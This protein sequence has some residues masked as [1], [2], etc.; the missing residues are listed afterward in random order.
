MREL[1][2][3]E[4]DF[5][6]LSLASRRDVEVVSTGDELSVRP[7]SKRFFRRGAVPFYRN[8]LTWITFLAI[9]PFVV[10]GIFIAFL[11]QAD[12]FL[13]AGTLTLIHENGI[14][15]GML[16]L[17]GNVDLGWLPLV[18]DIYAQRGLIIALI[19][20]VPFMLALLLLMVNLLLSSKESKAVSDA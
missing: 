15:P 6:E 4:R 19:F 5:I 1:N 14:P 7:K 20:T 8:I 12:S 18:A 11:V 10:A 2:E 13:G 3:Q 9:L 17:L 16:T